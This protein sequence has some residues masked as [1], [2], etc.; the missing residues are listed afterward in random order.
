MDES[1]EV[2]VECLTQR[3]EIQA[4]DAKFGGVTVMPWLKKK[5]QAETSGKSRR[6]RASKAMS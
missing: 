5:V 4:K 2:Q 3:R 6:L 1:G